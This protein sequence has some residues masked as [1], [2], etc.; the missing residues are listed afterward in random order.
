M[1]EQKLSS[2]SLVGLLYSS[3]YS[4][5]KFKELYEQDESLKALA[6]RVAIVQCI[7][8]AVHFLLEK[9]TVWNY[10]IEVNEN[11]CECIA[12][13]GKYYSCKELAFRL[14]YDIW[15]NGDVTTIQKRIFE[16]QKEFIELDDLTDKEIYLFLYRHLK[17]GWE[18]LEVKLGRERLEQACKSHPWILNRINNIP[19]K[20]LV[21]AKATR[22][23]VTSFCREIT[24]DDYV[25]NCQ[26]FVNRG[27]VDLKHIFAHAVSARNFNAVQNMIDLG[28]LDYNI[29]NPFNYFTGP[30]GNFRSHGS[31][32]SLISI[33]YNYGFRPN[34]ITI[35]ILLEIDDYEQIDLLLPYVEEQ[36]T[37][38]DLEDKKEKLFDNVEDAA[39]IIYKIL[40]LQ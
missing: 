18:Y 25:E 36:I 13:S 1:D 27:T 37:L 16:I 39:R 31:V 11:S 7:P 26:A 8:D 34:T 9:G 32:D 35:K 4:L 12:C 21:E 2:L 6:L 5:E 28:I 17:V 30:P 15:S 29:G 24:S 38:Q 40:S 23:E 3:N 22:E 10:H 19:L 14:S 20:S 33:L